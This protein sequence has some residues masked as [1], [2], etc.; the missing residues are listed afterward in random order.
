MSGDDNGEGLRALFY[1]LCSFWDIDAWDEKQAGLMPADFYLPGG[2][3]AY[4]VIV[5]EPAGRQVE[6]ATLLQRQ[7]KFIVLDDWDLDE[8]RT[9]QHK[10]AAAQ[11]LGWWIRNG[12]THAARERRRLGIAS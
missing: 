11:Q 2:M 5:P 9:R 10:V 12:D 4:V 8:F 3:G 7:E 6:I 1:G